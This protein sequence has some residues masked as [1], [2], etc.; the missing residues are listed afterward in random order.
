MG[1]IFDPL[2]CTC[3][4]AQSNQIWDDNQFKVWAGLQGNTAPN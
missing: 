3:N 2:L 4:L 1:H